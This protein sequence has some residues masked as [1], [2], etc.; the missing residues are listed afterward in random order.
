MNIEKLAIEDIE[1]TVECLP[2]H[3]EIQGN[4][5]ASGDDGVDRQAEQWV[6]DQLS[7][8]LAATL[9]LVPDYAVLGQGIGEC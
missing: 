1:Y 6:I 9:S 8:Q 5:M 4:V 3:A 2:E 7:S